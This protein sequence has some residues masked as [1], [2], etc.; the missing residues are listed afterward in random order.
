MFKWLAILRNQKRVIYL[1]EYFCS[2]RVGMLNESD[3]FAAVEAEN[4]L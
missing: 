4:I 3:R 2:H 1:N